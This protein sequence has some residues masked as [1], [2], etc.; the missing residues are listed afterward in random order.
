[1]FSFTSEKLTNVI[2]LLINFNIKCFAI[3]F[4]L[5]I[6]IEKTFL[7]Y[8]PF[9]TLGMQKWILY[10]KVTIVI[11]CIYFLSQITHRVVMLYF[12]LV[13]YFGIHAVFCAIMRFPLRLERVYNIWRFVET[14]VSSL[15]SLRL[16]EVKLNM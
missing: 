9:L 7:Q 15:P 11:F 1:M 2:S 14:E 13:Q 16:T 10:K 12:S 5:Y 3:F 6:T 4:K 8:Q